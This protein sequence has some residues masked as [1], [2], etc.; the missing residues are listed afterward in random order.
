MASLIIYYIFIHKYFARAS[1]KLR[2]SH[3]TDQISFEAIEVN[4]KKYM[5]GDTNNL[6]HTMG[7]IFATVVYL[8]V[9]NIVVNPLYASKIALASYLIVMML[10][11]RLILVLR[12]PIDKL[13]EKSSDSRQI[14]LDSK[15]NAVDNISSFFIKCRRHLIITEG[16]IQGAIVFLAWVTLNEFTIPT[17]TIPLPF[18][19]V[20]V[21]KFFSVHI[22][23]VAKQL[24]NFFFSYRIANIES[25][26]YDDVMNLK[27]KSNVKAKGKDNNDGESAIQKRTIWQRAKRML[28][29]ATSI[30]KYIIFLWLCLQGIVLLVNSADAIARI[31]AFFRN[32]F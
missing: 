6:P 10:L 28:N 22:L 9:V 8:S 15:N 11:I 18:A 27:D 26:E 32:I 24:I 23:I 29:P 3:I 1:I 5:N 13:I 30:A 7:L 20:L 14:V 19:I 4:S 31:I 21:S 25:F 16:L 2:M 12:F 17:T